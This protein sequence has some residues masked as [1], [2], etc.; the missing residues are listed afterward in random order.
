MLAAM[1][2]GPSCFMLQKPV[3]AS[4]RVPEG[5]GGGVLKEILKGEALPQC[6]TPYPVIK[7]L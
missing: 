2:V 7:L 5:G 6:M 1:S 3:S 4:A